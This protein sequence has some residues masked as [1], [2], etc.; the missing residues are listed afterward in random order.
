MQGSPRVLLAHALVLLCAASLAHA[1]PRPPVDRL[2]AVRPDTTGAAALERALADPA[3]RA[4]GRVTERESRFALPTFLWAT[5]TVTAATRAQ[6]RPAVSHADAARAHLA[7]VAPLWRLDAADV[8]GAA[9]GRVHDTG[10]GGVIVS[11]RQSFD[12]V[13]VFRDE[14]KLV[15]DRDQRLVSVSGYVPSHALLPKGAG[16]TFRLRADAAASRALADVAGVAVSPA[17]L[18]ARAARQGAYERFDLSAPVAGV[19]LSQPLRAKPVWFHLPESLVPAYYVEVLADQ[20]WYAYV[21]AAADGE[22]LFRHDLSAADSYSY[23]VWADA[24]APYSPW[25]GP[26]GTASSPHPTGLPDLYTAPLVAPQLVTLQ[27]SPFSAND[28]WLPPG[29]TET[30]GNNVDAYTDTNSPDG[31]NP[32]DSRATVTAPNAFDRVYDVNFE[33]SY[34]EQR[35]ASVTQLFFVN[36]F[37]HDWYY[38]A[39]FDEAAGNAQVSNYGRGGA[40]GDPLLAEAQDYSGTNNANMSCPADGGSPRMQMYIY[41]QPFGRLFVN[42][43]A[44]IAGEY[45]GGA[46]SFGSQEFDF[47]APVVAADDGAGTTSDACS[48]IVNDVAGKIALIDRGA[49][50][51]AAKVSAAEAAG[52]IGVI[53]VDNLDLSVPPRFNVSGSATIP[54]LTVTKSTGDMIRAQLGAGVQVRMRRGQTI[55]RD[56]T[57]QNTIVAHEW[58]HY[59]SNRLI[60]DATGLSTNMSGGMGEGWADFHAMLM[61]ARPGDDFHGVYSMSAYVK[62][63]TA[64]RSNAAYFSRRYP[65]STDMTKDPLTFRHIENGVALPAGP[66]LASGRDG[67]ANAEVHNTGEVWCTMLWECC[68]ALFDDSGR[69]TFE[70]A[71]TRMRD[72]LVASYK[73]TPAAPT[74]TEARDALLAVALANDPADYALFLNAFAKRGMGNGAV[75]PDRYA[76]GNAGVVESYSVGGDL[77][78][79]NLRFEL[80]APTCDGDGILDDGEWGKLTIDVR[81]IGATSLSATLATFASSD[82][83]VEFPNGDV[84][85]LPASSPYTTRTVTV[86]VR[87]WGATYPAPI[88]FTVSVA[89]PGLIGGPRTAIAYAFSQADEE[90]SATTEYFESATDP[91]SYTGGSEGYRGWGRDW[92]GWGDVRMHA[93]SS[94]STSDASATSPPMLIGGFTD[95]TI[96]FAHAY[97]IEEGFDGAVLELSADGGAT[98]TDLG[99]A[100]SEGGYTGVIFGENALQGRN[101][102]TGTSPGYPATTNVSINLSYDYAGQTVLLRYRM[103]T[104]GGVGGPGWSIRSLAV[105]DNQVQVYRILVSEQGSCGALAVDDGRPAGLDLSVLGANP[106]SGPRRLS[107]SLPSAQHVRVGIYDVSG[108]C[109]A[110]LAD[111]TYSAG[112]HTVTWDMQGARPAAGLYFARLQAGER[113]VGR[114]VILLGAR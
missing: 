110:T 46:V 23:R 6:A 33:P 76:L 98:W 90:P 55:W 87:L 43:P 59:I 84:I 37:L 41:Y 111:G 29:A 67:A 31:Y 12:G 70:Q 79:G 107:F 92:F 40:E 106:A 101:G 57:L 13:E 112:V 24:T 88:A 66:P 35:Q 83:A 34:P 109:V 104:D 48:P 1:E 4:L 75:S 80:T 25:D 22:V 77:V 50:T 51:I 11:F 60:G 94:G 100:M 91:W 27:N 44:G 53:L 32:G 89:D 36:N 19:V 74:L 39:G 28:P 15:M 54:T 52:A 58:G 7:R 105:D 72:Y 78:V 42:T 99:P 45:Q 97:S 86:P 9:L 102:W 5:P 85:A 114:R 69:L 96:Q 108:R 38:D 71:R 65:V 2:A 73:A 8:R 18:R 82:P 113:T 81:N 49:C 61:Q 103:A 21:V 14:M 3:A 95:F 30:N 17:S 26:E 16:R 68:V 47:I 10:R 63:D 64:S 20:D 93:T 62:S 56:G